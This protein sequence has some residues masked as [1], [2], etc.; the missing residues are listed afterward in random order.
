MPTPDFTHSFLQANGIR[1]HAVTCGETNSGGDQTPFLLLHGFPEFWYSWRYIMPLLA[2]PLEGPMHKVVAVDLRGYN[3]S[4]KPPHVKDYRLPTLC[5]DVV[6]VISQISPPGQVYLVGHD[7]GGALAW[8]V[9]RYYP[10]YVKKLFILNCPPAD[11]LFQSILKIP[12][13]LFQSYYIFLFQIPLLIEQ[14][15][16][17]RKGAF[18]RRFY[19]HVRGPDGTY[20]HPEDINQYVKAYSIPRAASGVNYY[21]AALRDFILRRANPHPPKVSCFTKVIWG[22]RDFALNVR[23]TQEFPEMVVPGKLRIKYVRNGT[24]HVQQNFPEICAQEI[25][26]HV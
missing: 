13:Q 3:L 9:A 11:V 20:L 12:R 16:R 2:A 22:V 14:L 6:D 18:I 24:H 7:W 23:L 21:R 26:K 25:L 10:Q 17:H 5:R 19:A 4:S 15:L 1:I 8:D